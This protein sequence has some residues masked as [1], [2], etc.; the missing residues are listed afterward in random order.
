MVRKAEGA[1]ERLRAAVDAWGIGSFEWDHVEGRVTGCERFFEL[2]ASPSGDQAGRMPWSAVHGNDRA[3]TQAAFEA[4]LDPAGDGC[5]DLIHRVL[6]PGG[7]SLVLHVRAQTRFEAAG[8]GRQP[9]VTTGSVADVTERQRIEEQLRHTEAR[10][11]EAVRSAQFGIFEHN[12]IEDPAAENVYWSPRLREIFGVTDDEPGSARKLLSRVPPDDIAMLHAAVA[13]AHQPD[14]NGYY[15]VEHR[16][17]HPTLGLRWLLTRS[18]TSFTELDGKRVPVRTVGAIIDISRERQLEDNMRQAQKMEAI[19]RLA[20]GI[21]HDFNNILSAILSF[22]YVAADEIG[23]TG[24]GYHELQGIISAGKRAAGLTQQLLAFSRK[25]V[26]RPRVVDVGETLTQMVPMLQRLMGEHI[27]VTL[28]LDRA[29]LRVKVDPTHLEQVLLNLAINARDAMEKG[30]RLS[31]QCHTQVVSEALAASR[32]G[33]EPGRYVV[34]TVSDNGV[35]MDAETRAHVFEPFF[36]TKAAGRG[37]G[38]GLATVFGIVKQ[39]GG[40]LQ[41]DSELG[42]GSTFQAYF[43]A[44]TEPLTEPS[45]ESPQRVFAAGGVILVA[46]DDPAVRQVVVTVLERAGY[47]VIPAAN[48]QEALARARE[49]DGGIDLLLTDIVMPLLSG[50]E[51]AQRLCAICPNL[52]VVYMSGYTDKNVFEGGTLDTREDFLPKPV[53][54]AKLLDIVARVLGRRPLPPVL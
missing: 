53:I 1:I 35:G 47:V 2:Y 22:A 16:Y 10:F 44:S 32:V 11:D 26:L 48:P 18:S 15:D 40:S 38:L 25:Q 41:V 52:L 6:H 24:K 30:G 28:A 7:R 36:T 5:I 27:D 34:I 20:G 46:E 39:S 33:L 31:I 50:T 43:P 45:R 23:A 42:Y 51:L 3:R 29:P 17:M 49:R 14:G 8:A 54:P 21:A 9:V 37:T 12:H 4:A 13:R 19:G